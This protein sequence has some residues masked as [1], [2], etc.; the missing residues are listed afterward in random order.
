[1]ERDRA[2]REAEVARRVTDFTAGLFA[3][4]NPVSSG[5]APLS[6]RDLLDAGV[7]RLE[8]QFMNEPEDV[9][10]ALFEKRKFVLRNDY[11]VRV[12]ALDA[13]D[14]NAQTLIDQA[15]AN[16]A[17]VGEWLEWLGEKPLPRSTNAK[18]VA[19]RGAELLAAYPHL[20]IHTKHF[21]EPYNYSLLGN[22]RTTA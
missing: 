17:Q 7:Q 5:G 3:G 15:C 13:G 11:M 8:S 19:K 16:A 22:V 18:T 9:Q 20:C 14:K 6:A 21:D 4:A 2:N 1:V 12:S 10:A